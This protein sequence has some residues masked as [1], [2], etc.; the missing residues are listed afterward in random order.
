MSAVA[1]DPLIAEAKRRARLRRLLGVVVALVAAAGIAFG[2]WTAFAGGGSGESAA[3]KPSA[4]IYDL[5]M[6]GGVTW[7]VS[8]AGK[9]EQLWLSAT[10]GENWF[11]ANLPTLPRGESLD[12]EVEFVDARHGWVTTSND[13]YSRWDIERT[14]DGG[15]TWQRATPPG[16]GTGKCV[17]DNVGSFTFFDAEHGYFQAY[18]GGATK[19]FATSNGGATW[20]LVSGSSRGASGDVTWVDP[21][22]GIVDNWGVCGPGGNL[23][24]DGLSRTSD[25][26]R[27][28]TPVAPDGKSLHPDV[29]LLHPGIT[30]TQG[31]LVVAAERPGPVVYT[32][33]DG[34]AHWQVH[35]GPAHLSVTE[36]LDGPPAYLFSA[37]S[38]D[39]WFAAD[40]SFR[41]LFE[42]T[43]AGKSWQAVQLPRAF[44]KAHADF[45]APEID[46]ASPQVGLALLPNFELYRTTDAG[47]HWARA[48]RAEPK[49]HGHH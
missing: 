4:P 19:L 20:R 38:P 12:G 30:S 46:F 22:H 25:G 41:H 14:T 10:G 21:Q 24:P 17:S 35:P 27:T 16:C 31:T 7:V 6:S 49:R 26:G 15:R 42:T 11:K 5:G 44:R 18:A 1:L 40:S 48:S 28:W 23:C 43:D 2:A 45:L 39:T 32:S 47:R 34:G 3:P 36:L 37:P 8:W 9:S 33:R 13:T 29:F